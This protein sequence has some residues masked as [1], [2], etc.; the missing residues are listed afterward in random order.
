MLEATWAP[1]G[2]TGMGRG[3]MGLLRRPG[4]V[5]ALTVPDPAVVDED[6]LGWAL[7]GLDYL[8]LET[9]PVL[10]ADLESLRQRLQARLRP[11]R[12]T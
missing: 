7:A 4:A 10:M 9:G 11:R 3:F 2:A 12:A 6:D 1:A 8:A 5:E